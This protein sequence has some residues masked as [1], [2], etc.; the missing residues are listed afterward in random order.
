MEFDE[1]YK[2][3]HRIIEI[4]RQAIENGNLQIL[5]D[6]REYQPFTYNYGY[7]E[8]AVRHNNFEIVKW[9]KAIGCPI[10]LHMTVHCANNLRL[11]KWAHEN[12]C[13]WNEDTCAMAAMF[14]N[15]DTLQ[16]AR[17]HG[18]PWDARTC[19]N[20]ARNGHLHILAW[21]RCNGCPWDADT[22]QIACVWRQYHIMDWLLDHDYPHHY[23]LAS[24]YPSELAKL[25]IERDSIPLLQL[26]EENGLTP[27]SLL[28]N[29]C[30]EFNR[31]SI[32]QYLH[33][34]NYPWDAELCYKA[35]YFGNFD[36]LK[37][38][39]AHGCPWNG[40]IIT[41]AASAGHLDIL[42]WAIQNGCTASWESYCE[43]AERMEFHI[44]EWLLRNCP[45]NY[46]TYISIFETLETV[47]YSKAE[48]YLSL[49]YLFERNLLRN[50]E[51]KMWMNAIHV[52][53]TDSIQ[54]PDLVNV[55]K[56][57]I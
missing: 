32:L 54:V 17:L 35:A 4:C 24:Y 38:A 2:K 5:E 42:K 7:Y 15:E 12:R 14:G 43:A 37:W 20:A 10:P 50:R 51:L 57:F 36:V 25:A 22:Y 46:N 13:R 27:T 21:A 52:Q 9:L 56:A 16:W 40:K 11:L 34:R 41:A 49:E 48:H 19:S 6:V 26:A 30:A 39:R 23:L 31:L 44:L 29:Y 47:E 8:S 45:C 53:L 55:I 18:C 28:C 33:R 3:Y 1:F